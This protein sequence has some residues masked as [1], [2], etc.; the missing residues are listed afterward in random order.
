MQ[1]ASRTVNARARAVRAR[2][3]SKATHTKAQTYP[4]EGAAGTQR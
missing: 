2:A 1:L 4:E 3:R